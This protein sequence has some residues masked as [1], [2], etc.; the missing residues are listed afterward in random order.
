MSEKIKKFVKTVGE[1][2]QR[3]DM[4]CD[5]CGHRMKP[6]GHYQMKIDDTSYQF[7]SEEC[8]NAYEAKKS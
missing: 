7:C 2:A 1:K 8:M 4:G 6:G 3:L 5:E